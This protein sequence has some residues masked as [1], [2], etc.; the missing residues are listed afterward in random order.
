VNVKF[1]P[2]ANKYDINIAISKDYAGYVNTSTTF[3]EVGGFDITFDAAGL[4][5]SSSPLV[6]LISGGIAFDNPSGTTGGKV[7]NNHV[8]PLYGSEQYTHL[9]DKTIRLHMSDSAGLRAGRTPIMYKGLPAGLVTNITQ[10]SDGLSAEIRINREFEDLTSE[11]ARFVLVKPKFSLTEV[12]GLST[13]LT[14]TYIEFFPYRGEP[15]YEFAL[16]EFPPEKGEADGRII[17]LSAES[18]GSLEERSGIFFKNIQIGHITAIRLTPQKT[19]DFTAVV[20]ADYIKLLEEGLYFSRNEGLNIKL[21]SGGVDIGTQSI[22]TLIKGGITA[23]H[24]GK[25]TAKSIYTLFD[26]KDKSQK[27]FYSDSGIKTFKILTETAEGFSQGDPIFYKG[28]VVGELSSP[29]LQSNGT[30]LMDTLIYPKYADL[31]TPSSLFYKA[32]GIS[33]QADSSG[34]RVETPSLLSATSGG[35]SFFNPKKPLNANT[36]GIYK[37][38]AN[39]AAA[40][41][42]ESLMSNG[43]QITLET[44]ASLPPAA[45]ASVYY[46]NVRAGSVLSTSLDDKG[47]PIVTLLIDDEF[48]KFVNNTTRFW[49]DGGIELRADSTGISLLTKPVKTYF[50]SAVYFDSFP[51]T[52]N[53]QIL[54]PNASAAR[55]ADMKEIKITFPYAINIKPGASVMA[56]DIET[57]Y[58]TATTISPESTEVAVLAKPEFASYFSEGALFWASD[59]KLSISGIE[60]IDS[61]FTGSKIAM[62][63]GTG[64]EKTSFTASK[65]A[66]SPF[67]GRKGL[68]VILL[69]PLKHSLEVGSPVFYRQVETGGVETIK[70]ANDGR[71]VEIG[72]FIEDKYKELV[73][74]GTVFWNSGGISTKINLLGVKVRTEPMKTLLVGGISFATPES[75]CPKAQEGSVFKLHDELKE[76]WL[77]WSPELVIGK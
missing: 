23:E 38:Y 53:Q 49:L 43:L 3:W 76:K 25:T 26:D 29:S 18:K 27:A 62:V 12:S 73:T 19:V 63:K 70:L 20:Y 59:V 42:A 54:Y 68:R 67:I 41:N 39:K 48:T 60:N 65:E 17:K 22:S 21:G 16:L 35:I 69:S 47:K 56:N 40:E 10:T 58:V 8:F 66:P 57:G 31:L 36:N 1:D 15:V 61:I 77:K 52:V 45:G 51:T 30:I 6:G 32:S 9:S 44:E 74:E 7:E 55:E 4:Q 5:I 14:G 33:F 24:Y 37:L 46:K 13:I 72:I 2:E 11:K 50:E 75:D 64:E 34:F 28:L 71:N